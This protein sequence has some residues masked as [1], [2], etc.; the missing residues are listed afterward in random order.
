[1]A[2]PR[3]TKSANPAYTTSVQQNELALHG[4]QWLTQ[5]NGFACGLSVALIACRNSTPN[6]PSSAGRS[7]CG[8]ACCMVRVEPLLLCRRRLVR[9]RCCGGADILG[10]PP[11][12]AGR[13]PTRPDVDLGDDLAPADAPAEP[14]AAAAPAGTGRERLRAPDQ[15]SFWV[16]WL[17][18]WAGVS[19]SSSSPCPSRGGPVRDEHPGGPA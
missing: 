9:G 11:A 18:P 13:S 5:P 16:G 6:Q 14:A 4:A 2:S 17:M 15:R 1:M 12:F 8:I 7:R 3:F 10:G 19:A